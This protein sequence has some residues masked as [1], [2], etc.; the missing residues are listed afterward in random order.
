MLNEVCIA[1]FDTP[2]YYCSIFSPWFICINGEGL[3]YYD[4]EY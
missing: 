3:S 2:H 1:E 4:H